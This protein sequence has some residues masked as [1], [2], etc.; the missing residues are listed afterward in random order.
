MY[1]IVESGALALDLTGRKTSVE[2][3][4]DA[5]QRAICAGRLDPGRKL[6]LTELAGALGMSVTPVREALRQLQRER[7]VVD[8][9][10]AGMRV[11]SLSKGELA[12]LFELLGVLEGMASAKGLPSLGAADL[13]Q[14]AAIIKELHGAATDGDAARFMDLN[15]AFH[16][17][18]LAPGAPAGG[19]LATI[20]EQVR[21]HTGR[22]SVAARH[23]LPA[24]ALHASNAEHLL[25][26]ERA[27]AGDTVG[28]EH[29][30]RRHAATFSHNLTRALGF[31]AGA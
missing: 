16:A 7:L 3:A 13:E 17:I 22:Y 4:R 5:L 23:A 10:Y 29:I 26:L 21:L 1:L 18:F 11:A 9:P 20:M 12:E 25:I 6:V 31:D 15:D 28:L 27:S 24:D 2:Q 30:C 14:A 8:H 19:T